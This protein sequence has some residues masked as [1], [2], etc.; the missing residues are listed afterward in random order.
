MSKSLLLRF[1]S[2]G[3]AAP[4]PPQ[5]EKFLIPPYP[6]FTNIWKTLPCDV[7]NEAVFLILEYSSLW[8]V[9]Q[10]KRQEK[11]G[12]LAYK[13]FL[14]EIHLKTY[15]KDF[16]QLSHLSFE[17]NKIHA[18]ACYRNGGKLNYIHPLW[19]Y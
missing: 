2:P 9:K 17:T 11:T 1:P 10:K 5:P 7:R 6:L 12:Y 19:F 15:Q 4:R 16:L 8:G 3:N 18:A 14:Q 13:S